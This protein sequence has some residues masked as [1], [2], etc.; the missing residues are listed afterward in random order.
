MVA[1]Q[2]W[3]LTALSFSLSAVGSWNFPADELWR[4]L[5]LIASLLPSFPSCFSQAPGRV[6]P[7]WCDPDCSAIAVVTDVPILLALFWLR[8]SFPL[9]IGP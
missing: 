1:V 3:F 8:R 9:L 2:F 4:Q 6:L 7:A 5:A